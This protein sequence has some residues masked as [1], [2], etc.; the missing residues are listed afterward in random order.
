MSRGLDHLVLVTRDLDA[1][2]AHYQAMGFIVGA[3]N[4]HPW[5]TENRIVQFPGIF[6]ELI[7]VGEG[8]EVKPPAPGEFSFAWTIPRHLDTFGDGFAMLVVESQDAAADRQAFDEAGIGGFEPF[9]FERLAVMPD[10]SKVRV[11][12]TLTF[13]ADS[14]M[15]DIG[16]FSCQHHEPQNFWNPAFQ[17]HPNGASKLGGIVMLA[18]A[19][20]ATVPFFE[21]LTGSRAVCASARNMAIVTPRGSV[22]AMS[23]DCYRDVLGL[24]PVLSLNEGARLAAFKVTAPLEAMAARLEKAG[25]P[26]VRHRKHLAVAAAEN[27]GTALII[28]EPR[29]V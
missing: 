12:F 26:F 4:R 19:P 5:G 28:E 23:P 13:A 7:T 18:E 29:V 17:A 8:A 24:E 14:A 22:E 27:F 25:I 15:P 16:A 10:G 6:L 2:A 11:A 20:A 1:A 9:F 3:R 21:A